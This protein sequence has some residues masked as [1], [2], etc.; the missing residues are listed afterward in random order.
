MKV[1]SS[2]NY[3]K[4]AWSTHSIANGYPCGSNTI[5]VSLHLIQRE[6]SEDVLRDGFVNPFER[7]QTSTTQRASY[8]LSNNTVSLREMR[9]KELMSQLLLVESPLEIDEILRQNEEFLMEPII[10]DGS[11]LEKD[12]IYEVGM[13]IQERF[14]RYNSV[15]KQREHQAVN[16][17]VKN[18]LAAMREFVMSHS[19]EQS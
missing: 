7:K 8:L 10:T 16:G 14:D 2:S 6:N 3:C 18:I 17:Q 11:V 4:S 1:P 12:S 9:M 5:R 19:L 15:M 13:T